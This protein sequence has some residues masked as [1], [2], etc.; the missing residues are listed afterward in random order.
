MS[1]PNGLMRAKIM[2]LPQRW[3]YL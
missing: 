2:S 3:I 1:N